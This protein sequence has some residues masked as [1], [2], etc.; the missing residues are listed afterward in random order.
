MLKITGKL[1][2]LIIF[3]LLL[4]ILVIIVFLKKFNNLFEGFID[5]DSNGSQL[6]QITIPQYNTNS[7]VYKLYDNIFYDNTNANIIVIGGSETGTQDTIGSSIN[8]L[9]VFQRDATSQLFFNY[10]T[11][12]NNLLPLKNNMYN[13]TLTNILPSLDSFYFSIHNYTIFYIPFDKDTYIHIIDGSIPKHINTFYFNQSSNFYMYPS[14]GNFS[15]STPITKQFYSIG[16]NYKNSNNSSIVNNYY[17]LSR[18]LFQ[19]SNKVNYD[20]SNGSVIIDISGGINYYNRNGDPPV[21]NLVANYLNGKINNNNISSV[22]F[23]TE[24]IV[25]DIGQNMVLFIPNGINTIITVAR[26]SQQGNSDIPYL[27]S[28]TY[29]YHFNSTTQI[30]SLPQTGGNNSGNTWSGSGGSGGSG[31]G[32]YSGENWGGNYS[33]NTLAGN[34]WTGNNSV[35]DYYSNFFNLTGM[36]AQS[37]PNFNDYILKTSVVPPVCPSCPYCPTNSSGSVCTNCGGNGGDGLATT[38]NGNTNLGTQLKNTTSTIGDQ[39]NNTT[40]NIGDQ[41]KNTASNIGSGLHTTAKTI[42]SDIQSVASAVGSNTQNVL[43][44]VGSNTQNVLSTIGGDLNSVVNSVGSGISNVGNYIGSGFNNSNGYNG[45]G[46]NNS[47]N[48]YNTSQ[49]TNNSSLYSPSSNNVKPDI[50]NQYGALVAKGSTFMPVTASFSAF[51]K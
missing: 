42:G 20:I 12:S 43:S 39:L 13:N 41:L 49:Q 25:D 28:L 38:N 34:A 17:D 5:F 40:S 47:S 32:N 33:G 27:Y 48:G 11:S 37:M 24:I 10:D 50:Y 4:F 8:I 29:V 16:S 21:T 51:G 46:F 35:S 26:C 18:N 30:N 2:P 6:T 36:N 7:K 31:S 15:Q 9:E 19:L 45:S 1:S 3:I 14:T 44:A 23:N 22:P